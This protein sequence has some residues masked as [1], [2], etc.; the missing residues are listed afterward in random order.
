[1]LS[2][3]DYVALD[4]CAIADGIR[5]KEFS[6]SEVLETAIARAEA[7]PYLRLKLTEIGMRC[8]G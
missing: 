2:F 7:R 1:M 3:D 8:A 5:K 6:A 4:A